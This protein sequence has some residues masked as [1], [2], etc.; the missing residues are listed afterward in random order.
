MRSTI[1][2]LLLLLSG[3]ASAQQQTYTLFG[4]SIPANPVDPDPHAVTLGLKFYSTQAGTVSAIRFYRG[5]ANSN[6]YIARLYTAAGQQLG[7]VNVP[8][9]ARN[10]SGGWKTATFTSPISIS[11]NTTYIA[12]YYTSNGYYGAT[13]YGLMNGATSGPLI[14][15]SSAN[16]VYNYGSGFHFPTLTYEASNYFVDVLFTPSAPPPPTLQM[17]FNPPDPAIASSAPIGTLVTTAV[18]TWSDGSQ[19]TGTY[20]FGSPYG[21]DGGLV[22]LNNGQ[23]VVNGNLSGL[24][25]TDQHVTVSAT[26]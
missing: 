15:P 21:N 3:E 4:T 9:D 17:S 6:G 11:A 8:S 22:M 10:F 2:I 14:A 18:A 12:A 16:G 1:M 20:S 5:H 26:Q 19:F 13:N 7:Q 23:V 24:G 25:N